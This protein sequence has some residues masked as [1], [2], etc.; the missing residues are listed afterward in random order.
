MIYAYLY[1]KGVQ[2]KY[3]NVVNGLYNYDITVKNY[4]KL[5]VFKNAVYMHYKDTGNAV[6]QCL[7]V[8]CP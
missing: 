3:G 7:T 6:A 4:I 8:L 2:S 1:V 5:N